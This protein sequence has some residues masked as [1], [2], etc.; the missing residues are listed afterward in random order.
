VALRPPQ[1][2]RSGNK[3]PHGDGP[4]QFM[5]SATTEPAIKGA[6]AK[7]QS[8]DGGSGGQSRVQGHAGQG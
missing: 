5:G 3:E 2:C 6:E 8:D 1:G 7:C 4:G